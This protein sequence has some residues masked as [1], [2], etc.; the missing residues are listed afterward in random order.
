MPGLQVI[1]PPS[2]EPVSLAE[3]KLQCRVENTEDDSY[4]STILIPAAR[5]AVEKFC[6]RSFVS[7]QYIQTLDSFPYYADSVM[8]QQA[9]P[10]AYYSQ[11]RYSTT[12]W[13]YSQMIKLFRPPLVSV[14]EIKYVSTDVGNPSVVL[15]PTLY[16]VD[17]IGEPGRIFPNPGTMWP[18]C[19]YVPNAVQI[20]F[21][22]GVYTDPADLAIAKLAM[23]TL[24]ANWN[25]NR[26]AAAAGSYGEIPNH[27]QM[28]LWSIRFEDMAPTR[29]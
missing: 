12:F 5:G 19:F 28:L 26:E 21:T 18:A 25:E 15:D 9:Y 24:I 7:K 4:F 11:P 3:A 20:K 6:N 16:I 10:P 14:D 17:K 2:S 22:S 29:G 1:T 27:I 13:N 23:L 8:S